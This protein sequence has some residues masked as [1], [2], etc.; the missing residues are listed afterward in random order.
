MAKAKQK[1]YEKESRR[2]NSC[3]LRCRRI[4]SPAITKPATIGVNTRFTMRSQCTLMKC[5]GK[6]TRLMA[7]TPEPRMA[8]P[9]AADHDRKVPARGE[10]GTRLRAISS[11]RASDSSCNSSSPTN[12]RIISM[13]ASIRNGGNGLTCFRISRFER[14]SS[15]RKQRPPPPKKSRRQELLDGLAQSF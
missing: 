1:P 15:S 11:V 4:P 7:P 6:N 2:I 9:M 14:P 8:M 5:A 13:R 10:G 12:R 3:P